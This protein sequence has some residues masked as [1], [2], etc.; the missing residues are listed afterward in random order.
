MKKISSVLVA[1]I[2]FSTT[3]TY[4][5]TN[6][7]GLKNAVVMADSIDLNDYVGKYK[8]P[9]GSPVESVSFSVVDGKLVA[10]AGEYPDAVLAVKVKDVFEDAGM[11][12]I[13]TFS[14]VENKVM[15]L[16]IEVQGFE[17]LA[18]RVEEEKK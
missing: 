14:R 18:E 16:K 1:I 12:G 17:L 3:Y 2:L 7:S 9:E 11:G 15:K 4:A 10:K 13:F 6:D 8:L 5:K